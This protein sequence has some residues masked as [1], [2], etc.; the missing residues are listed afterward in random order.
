MFLKKFFKRSIIYY[1]NYLDHIYFYFRNKKNNL[2]YYLTFVDLSLIGDIIVSIPY[3]YNLLEKLNSREKIAFLGLPQTG[4][5]LKLFLNFPNLTFIGINPRYFIYNPL[6]RW[7]LLAEISSFYTVISHPNRTEL[8]E[9]IALKIRSNFRIAY[10]GEWIYEKEKK[11]N[12][13]KYFDLI[14]KSNFDNNK[15]THISRHLSTLFSTLKRVLLSSNDDIISIT[16]NDYYKIFKKNKNLL[17]RELLMNKYIVI[18]PSASTLYRR[19]PVYSFQKILDMLPKN[20]KILQIGLNKFPLSHPNLID[21]TGKT[22][23]EEAISLVMNASLVIGNETGLT[24]LA[25]L[26]GVPTVG[27]IGGGHFGRFLPWPEFNDIVK[28][29]YLPMNCFQC[30]WKCKY[31]NLQKGEVPPCIAE[32]HPKQV[33]EAI[34]EL[35]EKFKIF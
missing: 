4:T 15:I 7:S 12:K 20:I 28:T 23:L 10:E 21:L 1:N 24:H 17:K 27:I 9:L 8:M 16:K 18:I 31:V 3:Y 30:G 11:E 26:S 29:V 5:I 2:N 13:L 34:E 33:I 6:Y 25:Y 35:N 14:I 22:S 32:I 19:Y